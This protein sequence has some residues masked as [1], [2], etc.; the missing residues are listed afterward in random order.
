MPTAGSD[1][2][3]WRRVLVLLLGACLSHGLPQAWER[4]GTCPFWK[5]CEVFLCISS[6]SKTHSK[7]IIFATCRRLL[8]ASP[9]DPHIVFIPGPRWGTFV[10]GSLFCPPLEKPCGAHGLSPTRSFLS[11]P[12]PLELGLLPLKSS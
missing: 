2:H 10:P 9:T 11:P 7:R 6:Y 3:Q 5:C 4:E 12:L 1:T 8:G